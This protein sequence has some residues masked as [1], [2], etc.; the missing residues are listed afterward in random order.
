MQKTELV[1]SAAKLLLTLHCLQISCLVRDPQQH[2][3]QYVL[4]GPLT[5]RF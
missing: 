2:E 1:A 3:G 4:Q 5:M